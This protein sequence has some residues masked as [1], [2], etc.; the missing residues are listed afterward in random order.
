[1]LLSAT[2]FAV[3][4]PPAALPAPPPAAA[5]SALLVRDAHCRQFM[6]SCL[7]NGRPARLM[8]DTGATHT[9]LAAD[10]VEQQLPQMEFVEG[11]KL[12]GNAT[13]PP[14]LGVA[15]LQAGGQQ[16]G[17]GAVLVMPLEGVNTMLG[18][19]I[20]GILGMSHLGRL[21]FTLDLREGRQGHWDLPTETLPLL[22]LAGQR[23]AAGRLMLSARCG[24]T[25]CRLLLDS[26]STVTTWPQGQWPAGE[27]E[28]QELR[29]GDVNGAR[30]VRFS[31]GRAAALQ[32]GGDVLLPQIRPQ[33]RPGQEGHV[34]GLD[35]L[36]GGLLL[37]VPGKGFYVLPPT[38]M[39]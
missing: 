26:G 33:L 9:V 12:S 35:A 3:G 30:S 34:L 18:Q 13:T 2:G 20:D 8:V 7:V 15:E 1:M 37:H 27:E 36:E 24:N 23:D 31:Y 38:V 39:E 4:E 14:R 6:A 32:L 10:F 29:V 22:P 28:A 19:R 5:E 11:V 16:L 25:A 17:R 21:T